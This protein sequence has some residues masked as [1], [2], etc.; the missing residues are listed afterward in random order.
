MYFAVKRSGLRLL[1]QAANIT[2][3]R[4]ASFDRPI[5]SE[6]SFKEEQRAGLLQDLGAYLTTLKVN[7]KTCHLLTPMSNRTS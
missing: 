1:L 4:L 7:L 2:R 6:P 5:V 3:Q